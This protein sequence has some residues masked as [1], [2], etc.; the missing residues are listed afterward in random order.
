MK[1]AL[2]TA[3]WTFIEAS[4]SSFSRMHTQQKGSHLEVGGLGLGELTRNR[5]AVSARVRAAPASVRECQIPP[6]VGDQ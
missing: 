4:E 6:L 5:V 3:F 1:P 2:R